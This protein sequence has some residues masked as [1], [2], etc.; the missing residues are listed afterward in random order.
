M[1]DKDTKQQEPGASGGTATASTA[2][3]QGDPAATADKPLGEAGEK[4]LKAERDARQAAEK[5]AAELKR[6]LDQVNAANMTDLEKAQKEATD[7][8]AAA[9]KSAAEALRFRIAARHNISDADAELILTGPDEATMERQAAWAV[10]N[11]GQTNQAGPRP[12]LT[13]GGTTDPA[14]LNGDPLLDTLKDKLGIA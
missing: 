5:A 13:Q 3:P 12:D 4:A 14:A 6:Q 9:E 11:R 2:P 8:K 7:A 1:S 10:A